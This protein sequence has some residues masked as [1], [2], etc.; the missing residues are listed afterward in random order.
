MVQGD[1]DR[2]SSVFYADSAPRD[3]CAADACTGIRSGLVRR[4]VVDVVQ[5]LAQYTQ[6]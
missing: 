4:L 1:V 2:T 6:K 5:E 3:G